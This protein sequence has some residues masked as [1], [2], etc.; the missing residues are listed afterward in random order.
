MI[1]LVLQP[2]QINMAVF[3]WFLVKSDLSSVGYCTR[4]N[5]ISHFL[6]G[7]RITRPWITGHP[8]YNLDWVVTSNQ[9]VITNQV[10]SGVGIEYNPLLRFV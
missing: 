2:D 8:V 10:I 6:Q 4:V 7:T 3:L 9:A 5:R 1:I